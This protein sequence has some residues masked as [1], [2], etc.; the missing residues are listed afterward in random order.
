MFI[1]LGTVKFGN[2][3]YGYSSKNYK[4]IDYINFLLNVYNIGIKTLDTSPRYGISEKIIGEYHNRYI[5]KF[6][7]ST[8]VDNLNPN[9][10]N[11]K[12]K[13]ENSIE[14]SLK[15]LS[16]ES[17][18]ICYLHQNDIKI[19]SDKYIIDSLI[20]LKNKKIIKNIGVSIYSPEELDFSINSG[21][22]DY[23]QFPLNIF[24]S[25][26]YFKFIHSC[27]KP[28]KFIARS[29]FLQGILS[30][31]PNIGKHKYSNDI[32]IYMKNLIEIS[33]K[34]NLSPISINL[35]YL[36]SLK[37]IDRFIIGS[38]SINNLKK[39]I[40]FTKIKLPDY[41]IKELDIISNKKK[42]WSNPRNW[43]QNI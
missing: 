16:L 33:N 39:N 17:L 27:N 15:N 21:C 12:F 14:N 42:E 19:I 9:D 22:Y 6:N 24:D 32:S 18:D 13:I 2:L 36:S 28:V 26:L 1:S 10:K 35:S 40:D 5:K 8:K 30:K 41:I 34:I 31:Y 20:D 7:V 38:L 43:L 29:L 11:S 3:N 25:S 37:N 4:E 23:I